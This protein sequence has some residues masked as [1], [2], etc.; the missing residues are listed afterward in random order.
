MQPAVALR[1]EV[2]VFPSWQSV[3]M[4]SRDGVKQNNVWYDESEHALAT[5]LMPS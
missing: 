4:S 1:F 3:A 2:S 5:E